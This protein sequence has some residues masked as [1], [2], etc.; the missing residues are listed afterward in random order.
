MIAHVN[1]RIGQEL[2][3]APVNQG[4]RPPKTRDGASLVSLPTQ[5]EMVGNNTEGDGSFLCWW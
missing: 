2:K 5:A 1:H 3:N 4:G